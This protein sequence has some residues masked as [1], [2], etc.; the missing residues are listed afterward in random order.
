[1]KNIA[2]TVMNALV[3]AIEPP[4]Q[5][6][7]VPPEQ[8]AAL[9]AHMRRAEAGSPSGNGESGAPV[10]SDLPTNVF[11][12]PWIRPA[13]SIEDQLEG[14]A[15][16]E[17]WNLIAFR[18]NWGASEDIYRMNA[19]RLGLKP[20]KELIELNELSLRI[21]EECS[22]FSAKTG[23]QWHQEH[24]D[25]LGDE[26]LAGRISQVDG[27]SEDECEGERETKLVAYKRT[28]TKFSQR[29]F[30]ILRHD[31]AT[32][33]GGLKQMVAE[34]IDN[35]RARHAKFGFADKYVS[36][37]EIIK[38]IR[39]CQSVLE[40]RLAAGPPKHYAPIRAMAQG[41]FEL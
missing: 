21:W 20:S 24:L 23:A 41:V 13:P 25:Q 19:Q 26:I 22:R 12:P 27:Y 38:S 18:S 29:G 28:L 37:S 3:K 1:M 17:G 35:E 2:E 32:A 30:E 14:R 8:A 16:G 4:G 11:S 40:K 7:D 31:I 39:E 6:Q 36:P 5:Q 34:E 33:I 15:R 10:V 9:E